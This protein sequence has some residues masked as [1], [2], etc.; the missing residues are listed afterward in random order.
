MGQ[1]LTKQRKKRQRGNQAKYQPTHSDSQQPIVNGGVSTDVS[2]GVSQHSIDKQ[3]TQHISD[4]EII[5]NC[6]SNL[7][8]HHSLGF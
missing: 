8:F 1:C 2:A 5:G 6:A 4:R 7:R 3:Q